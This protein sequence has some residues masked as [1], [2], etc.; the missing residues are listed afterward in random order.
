MSILSGKAIEKEIRA[1]NIVV[2]P[3]R[4]E[5]LNPISIDLTLGNKVAVYGDLVH[6]FERDD[7][8]VE[9]GRHFM[10]KQSAVFDVKKEMFVKEF[11][12]SDIGWELRPGIGYLMH[13]HERISTDKYVPILDGKSSIG[14]AFIQIH[15]TAGVGDPGFDGQY[16]LE[17]IVTH[18]V[19]VYAGMRIAQMRFFEIEGDINSYQNTGSYK[20]KL[21]EGP[22]PSQIWKTFQENK[23][24][25]KK[26]PR[27]LR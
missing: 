21:A 15:V 27:D 8:T 17:V 5:M 6:C 2:D 19:R 10:S 4:K 22:I 16:T 20:G 3:F 23:S 7:V 26:F 11:T 14:R 25:T 13:T 24:K 1:G 12:I 18:P 9:D